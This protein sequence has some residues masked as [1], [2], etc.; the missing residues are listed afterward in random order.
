MGLFNRKGNN[1]A[2]FTAGKWVGFYRKKQ[3]VIARL[4]RG[5]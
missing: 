3:F 1:P 5:V 4:L 2:V